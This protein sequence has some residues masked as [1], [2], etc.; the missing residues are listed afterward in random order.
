MLS[1]IVFS[2]VTIVLWL[3]SIL[4]TPAQSHPRRLSAFHP[5]KDLAPKFT[6]NPQALSLASNDFG[7][8]VHK[9]PKAVFEPCSVEDISALINFS[10]SLPTPFTIATRGRAHSVSGQAMTQD[11]VVLNMTNLN[12]FKHGSRIKVVC[13]GKSSWGCYADVGGEQLW[14]DVLNAT[15]KHGLTPLS[16]TDYLYLTVGGTLSNA[17]INGGT[18][19]LGPQIS[20][21]LEL[22]VVT[23]KGKFVTCSPE[24]N[25]E[26]F[27]AVLGGLGQFGVITRARIPLRPS[28]TR[29]YWIHLLYNNFTT[30][31]KDQEYL[32]SF[33]ERSDTNAADY[34][35]GQL[36]LINQ[37]PLD[38]SFYEPSD[39]QRITSL[40]TQYGIIY[41]LEIAKYYDNNNEARVEQEVANLVKGLNF[42]PTFMF[43]KNVSYEE[44]L[45][46][47]HASELLLTSQGV[48]DVPHPWL[49]M[50][51]PSSQISDFN[52]GVF[53]DII[54]KQN[55][56]PGGCLVYPMNRNKWD[57][58]MSAVTPKEDVF[59]SVN[60]FRFAVQNVEKYEVQNQKI[61]QF[62]KDADIK[63]KEYL[64]GNKTHQEWVEHFGLKWKLFKDRKAKFDPN[65]ILSP[66]Q[67]IF[68]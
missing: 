14:I 49:N 16:F 8:I 36:L 53:K 54:L 40:V 11:G 18:F 27:Y 44:F 15:L 43:K 63:I 38:L 5:P 59:Y 45:G 3:L 41:V 65:R 61:L 39:Q 13:D 22:D 64:A 19:L 67:G 28:P 56:S 20:N 60:L 17:G 10:N 7:K 35:E 26:V 2:K 21:V 29:V 55:I 62:C 25:S 32:I 52:E 47:V 37:S 50:F 68:Q 23:G 31:S 58:R 12:A 30:F 24:K 51:V 33:N 9:T 4:L 48:W 1:N 6:R 57:D 46:R 42:L 66:G 34:I